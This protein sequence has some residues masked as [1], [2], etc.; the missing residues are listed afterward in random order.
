MIR[1]LFAAAALLVLLVTNVSA[2]DIGRVYNPFD[3]YYYDGTRLDLL[4]KCPATATA[5]Q[6]LDVSVKPTIWCGSG[7]FTYK[8]NRMMVQLEGNPRGASASGS[9]GAYET[10]WGPFSR[11]FSFTQDVPSCA[12]LETPT[13]SSKSREFQEVVVRVID[14]VPASL[15]GTVAIVTPLA[16]DEFGNEP[17]YTYANSCVVPVK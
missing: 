12:S 16:V 15:V 6:P 1:P 5:G 17:M 9:V 4:V 11:P 3:F 8:L 14:A 13:G 10:M 7:S 2:A